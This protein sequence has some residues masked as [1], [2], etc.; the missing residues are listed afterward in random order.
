MPLIGRRTRVGTRGRGGVGANRPTVQAEPAAATAGGMHSK[1]ASPV[2]GIPRRRSCCR[3]IGHPIRR[4]GRPTRSAKTPAH[5]QRKHRR[6]AAHC[7]ERPGF[8]VCHVC[9]CTDRLCYRP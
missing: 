6:A 8:A 5:H 4:A 3:H 1:G 2:R 7:G 9:H